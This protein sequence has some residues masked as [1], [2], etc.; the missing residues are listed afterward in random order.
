MII[1]V[2]IPTYKPNDYLWECLDSISRQTISHFDFEVVVVL[3]GCNEPYRSLIVEYIKNHADINYV[4]IQTDTPGVS[5]ARNIGMDRS[6]G[7]YIAFIDDD[8]YVSP[9]YL[10]ELYKKAAPDT[11]SVCYPYAF[12]DGAPA[13]QLPYNLTDEFSVLSKKGKVNYLKVKKMFSGPCM[14]M[15]H[16]DIVSGRRFDCKLKNG[17][18]SLFMFLL[19]DKMKMVDFTSNNA[20]YYRRFRP[21]S[22]TTRKLSW[23]YVLKNCWMRFRLYSKIYFSDAKHYSFYRYCCGLRGISHIL[24]SR[25][26]KGVI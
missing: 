12:N 25:L 10:D 19:T 24:M 8:D 21:N 23:G 22:A 15:I 7:D 5:N 4:L 6:Q 13:I 2:I 18:D 9:T 1:S 14:K 11:I 3:N 26:L 17:E 20:V 16:K